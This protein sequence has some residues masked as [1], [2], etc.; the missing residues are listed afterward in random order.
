MVASGSSGAINP[1]KTATN[2][3]T[4]RITMPAV[5]LRLR[6]IARTKRSGSPLVSRPLAPSR[7][8]G[9]EV[10]AVT[11]RLARARIEDRRD[12]VGDQDADQH[13]NRVEQEQA[14]HQRQ[15]VIDRGG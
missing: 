6:R 3:I 7:T 1:G 12:H 8:S 9:A 10:P 15:I 13:R 2:A 14:L 5:A 4:S 11:S